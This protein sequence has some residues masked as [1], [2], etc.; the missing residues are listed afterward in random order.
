MLAVAALVQAAQATTIPINWGRTDR[1]DGEITVNFDDL[2]G[3]PLLGQSMS[4][5]FVFSAHPLHVRADTIPQNFGIIFQ[6]PTNGTDF[7]AWGPA[8]GY[9]LGHGGTP[10]QSPQPVI[11]G[12]GNDNYVFGPSMYPLLTDP[13]GTPLLDAPPLPFTLYGAHF[14]LIFPTDA[15]LSVQPGAY[16]RVVGLVPDSGNT[17][18]LLVFGLSGVAVAHYAAIKPVHK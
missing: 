7:I 8:S 9:L 13:Y 6:L 4:L 5:D 16:F 18:V 12:G 2:A 17:V 15:T 1:N 11:L 14:D 10:M 3:A